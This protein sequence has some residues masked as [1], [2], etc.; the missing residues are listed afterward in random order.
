MGGEPAMPAPA[1]VRLDQILGPVQRATRPLPAISGGTL[2][3]GERSGR[4]VAVASDPEHDRIWIIDPTA[5]SGAP[6]ERP[7][8]LPAGAEP[9]RVVIAGER[10]FVAL[11]RRGE[12][13]VVDLKSDRITAQV[14][15]CAAP[16]GLAVE[17]STDTLAVA[18]ASG[19]LVLW[20]ASTME[21]EASYELGAD[22]R[23]VVVQGDEILVSRFRSAEL[24]TVRRQDGSV[25]DRGA[26]AG[27][28]ELTSDVLP[29]S[30]AWRMVTGPDGHPVVLHQLHLTRA[31]RSCRRR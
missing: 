22:L 25:V 31:G 28:L 12:V 3:V 5:R 15:V 30:V 17:A 4:S 24:L 2:A 21:H 29:A 20:R 6:T 14:A 16:R 11:R 18:C 19:E 23:D 9:G 27:V 1:Q 13:A 10:A 26:P 7:I 8:D